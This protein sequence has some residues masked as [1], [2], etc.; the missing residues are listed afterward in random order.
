[1]GLESAS[2]IG[3]LVATN[4]VSSDNQ[5]QGDD[6]LRLL[7]TVL[8]A[9]FPNATKTFYFP[10]FASKTTNYTVLSTEQNKFFGVSASAGSCTVT[11]PSLTSGAT[12]WAV[13]VFK[14]D[15]SANT[16]TVA[17]TI[18]GTVNVVLTKQYQG[19][20]F[21]WSGTAW[22]AFPYIR[23][24]AD[25]SLSVD[26]LSA[27]DVAISGF[28]NVTAN[29]RMNLPRGT[30]AQRPGTPADGDFRLNSTLAALEAYEDGQW[31]TLSFAHP[32]PRGAAE[33]VVTNGT[34]PAS[35]IDVDA[36]AVTVETTS[37]IAY[38]LT[39][40]NVTINLGT[41]GANG[42]DTGGAPIDNWLAVWVI[43][44]PS[45]DAV[46]GLASLSGTAPTMPAGYTAK[47]RVGWMRTDSAADLKRTLQQGR[48]VQ[49]IVTATVA[50]P[51]V[52]SGTGGTWDETSASFA[53]KSLSNFVPTTAVRAHLVAQ[54][55]NNGS[56]RPLAMAPNTEYKGPKHTSKPAPFYLAQTSDNSPLS[57]NFEFALEG[58]RT[59]GLVTS[60][61]GSSFFCLGWEDNL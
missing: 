14:S 58:S 37:N 19:A 21:M 50:L 48:R 17:G 54:T 51:E 6:H 20:V 31:H 46:A 29:D 56:S 44:K 43:Y 8:K 53:S 9:N 38:R 55:G 59:F 42:M 36:D 49:Y 11:L 7:K 28:L 18:N 26:V 13:T 33:L 22:F 60:G 16:V 15:S 30:T 1:M 2:F 3:D 47:A 61:S 40:V 10:D 41:T 5:S 23:I 35:M 45:T 27:V 57:G 32:I 39:E 52:H 24:A 25:G 34:T 12:G 4:P